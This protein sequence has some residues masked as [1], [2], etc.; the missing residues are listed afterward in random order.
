MITLFPVLSKIPDSFN[1]SGA[2]SLLSTWIALKLPWGWM[3][4]SHLPAGGVR[5]RPDAGLGWDVFHSLLGG[6]SYDGLLA[7]LESQRTLAGTGRD[8]PGLARAEVSTVQ[9]G[10]ASPALLADLPRMIVLR[11]GDCSPLETVRDCV[12]ATLLLLSSCCD[13]LLFPWLSTQ[14]CSCLLVLELPCASL[15]PWKHMRRWHMLTKEQLY[16]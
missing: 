14:E 10:A 4:Y 16:I 6:F 8:C 13:R 1:K 5:P 11:R 9:G 2:V 3:V 7:V 15:R 12:T